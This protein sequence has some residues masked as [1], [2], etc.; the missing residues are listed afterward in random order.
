MISKLYTMTIFTLV[1]R[2]KESKKNNLIY[3]FLLKLYFKDRTDVWT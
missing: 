2:K 1:I 3:L